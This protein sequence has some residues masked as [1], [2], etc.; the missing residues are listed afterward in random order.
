VLGAVHRFRVPRSGL[1]QEEG[2]PAETRAEPEGAFLGLE[3]QVAEGGKLT[4]CS[5]IKS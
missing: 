4:P 1:V 5:A 3:T 2:M